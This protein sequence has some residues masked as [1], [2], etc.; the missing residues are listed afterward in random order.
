[1]LSDY[2]RPEYRTVINAAD[3]MNSDIISAIHKALPKAVTQVQNLS[4][5]FQAA[6]RYETAKNI[7]LFLKN[8]IRYV[9]DADEYQKIK[10][11]SR[12]LSEGT[13][14]CKSLSLFTAAILKSL[15]MPAAFR[16]ASYS[17]GNDIPSH[18]YTT[19]QDERG[20]EI[21]IDAVWNEFNSEKKYSSK[22]DYQM[23][24]SKR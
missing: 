19:T 21:I 7:W 23:R 2:P 8:N 17:P 5:H 1:M 12:L 24:E 11:P 22:K 3:G 9:R 14:D 6:S 18:V 13:G 20:N 15:D 4:R 10:L 16:Y